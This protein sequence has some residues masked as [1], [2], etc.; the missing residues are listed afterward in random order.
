LTLLTSD[1][2][3]TPFGAFCFGTLNRLLIPL[4]LHQV[5]GSV[6]GLGE[7]NLQA[8]AAAQPLHEGYMAASTPSSCSACRAPASPSGCTA[9]GCNA[10]PG[11]L[12]AYS[13]AHLGSGGD[14]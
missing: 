7:S 8:L 10:C 6:V 14:Y 12:A 5:L 13:G 11:G 2:L 9:S 3:T 1:L 4:G